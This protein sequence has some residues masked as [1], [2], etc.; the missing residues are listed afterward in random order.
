MLMTQLEH[1]ESVQEIKRVLS[2]HKNVVICCGWNAP[3][4]DHIYQIM[5]KLELEYSHVT[6]KDLDFD[7]PYANFIKN[8]PECALFK[9]I[10]FIIYYLRGKIVDITTCIQSREQIIE[11]L[12]R[13][14]GS[15][16][17]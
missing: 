5:E 2:N 14:F 4:C 6:F 9:G 8:L 12:D 10:P 11:I 1:L 13:E 17:N 15:P 7:A 3:I 16:K